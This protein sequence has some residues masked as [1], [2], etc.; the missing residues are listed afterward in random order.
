[1]HGPGGLPK[2]LCKIRLIKLLHCVVG[3]VSEWICMQKMLA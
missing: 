1:M 2:E 3:I